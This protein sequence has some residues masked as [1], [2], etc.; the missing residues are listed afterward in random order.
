MADIIL[1]GTKEKV[2]QFH[3]KAFGK[4]IIFIHQ[5]YQLSQ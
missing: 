5:E 3:F 2:I 4:N 1:T